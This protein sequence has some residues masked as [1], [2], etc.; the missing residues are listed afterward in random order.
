MDGWNTTFLFGRPMFRGCVSLREGQA[1][2]FVR[3]LF[4][5]NVLLWLH[6][7]KCP[8]KNTNFQVATAGK[9]G[10]VFVLNVACRKLGWST[11]VLSCIVNRH[12]L[13]SGFRCLHITWYS[14]TA[15]FLISR[16]FQ[17]KLFFCFA[18]EQEVV[19]NN[20]L[21]VPF[22][23]GSA[24]MTYHFHNHTHTRNKVGFRNSWVGF[25]NFLVTTRVY[26]RITYIDP[27]TNDLKSRFLLCK[28]TSMGLSHRVVSSVT[29]LLYRYLEHLST[30]D[31]HNPGTS[32]N[33]IL[34]VW[35]ITGVLP[36]PR[37]VRFQASTVHYQGLLSTIWPA[38][39]M[40]LECSRVGVGQ[41]ELCQYFCIWIHIV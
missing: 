11:W 37:G 35:A 23:V 1:L 6:F 12:A 21:Y 19:S 39:D 30:V 31:G 36:I 28:Q 34:H 5:N 38:K 41:Q 27:Y 29:I 18:H 33:I 17:S 2:V 24:Y 7:W 25:K 3:W 9:D 20:S 8:E 14:K 40:Q 22:E 10:S 13:L 16:S 26:I 15:T 4:L 32:W